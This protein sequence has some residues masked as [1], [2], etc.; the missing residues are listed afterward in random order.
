[1]GTTQDRT[2]RL[3]VLSAG[4]R[5]QLDQ[6]RDELLTWLD[7]HPQA[8]LDRIV[9]TLQTGREALTERL[10]VVVST[11]GELVARLRDGDGVVLGTAPAVRGEPVATTDLQEAAR[12]WVQGT[13]VR[14]PSMPSGRPPRLSLPQPPPVTR[15]YWISPPAALVAAPAERLLTGSEFFLRD[16]A[17][18]EVRVLPAVAALEFAVD[19]AA[20]AGH[21]QASSI[22]NVLW[23][24]PVLVTDEPV[25][26]RLRLAPAADGVSYELRRVDDTPDGELCSTG[27]LRFGRT[28][29][30]PRID[31]AAVRARLPRTA[32][33]R[34]CYAVFAALG[35][36][37]GPSLQGVAIGVVHTG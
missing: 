18:G 6:Y 28:P 25:R 8:S 24:R 30:A 29:D 7:A 12:L 36:G 13:P 15:R 34:D 17:L 5:E 37:Y 1:M 9:G 22:E 26:V 19:A 21:G 10:A 3:V 14:W 2:A 27:T 20:R 33:A 31:L 35:G 32:S 23:A 11:V 16:H 4:G